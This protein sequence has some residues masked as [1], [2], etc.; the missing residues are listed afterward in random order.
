MQKNGHKCNKVSSLGASHSWRRGVVSFPLLEM[1][2]YPWI[3][4]FVFFTVVF[5]Q[6]LSEIFKKLVL[7]FFYLHLQY[8]PVITRIVLHFLFR[9][10][11]QDIQVKVMRLTDINFNRV[12][13]FYRHLLL[14]GKKSLG[15]KNFPW[16]RRKKI[17]KANAKKNRVLVF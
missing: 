4:R 7:Y 3:G 8:R 14:K 12:C 9:H 5:F 2:K 1:I 17:N 15:F 13:E 10:Y 16:K 6:C 11:H